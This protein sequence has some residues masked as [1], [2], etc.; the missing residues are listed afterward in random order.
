MLGMTTLNK[1]VWLQLG[2][3]SCFLAV[4]RQ[5][6]SLNQKSLGGL[7]ASSQLLLQMLGFPFH[8]LCFPLLFLPE[9]GSAAPQRPLLSALQ[10][11]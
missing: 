8:T 5:P 3:F 2:I 1:Q 9:E 7:S 11:I 10:L 6:G 4:S